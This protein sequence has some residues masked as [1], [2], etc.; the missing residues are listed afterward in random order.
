MAEKVKRC[1][2]CNR[3]LR[4]TATATD[5]A[6]AL[7][8]DGDTNFK[9]VEEIWCPDCTSS[10]EHLEREINDA[11]VDYLWRGDRIL[12]WPKAASTN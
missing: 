1:A 10:D 6:V 9:V 11:T 7:A 5:W 4:N 8:P 3:R 2:R 12:M